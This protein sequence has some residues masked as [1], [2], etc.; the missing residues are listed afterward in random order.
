MTVAV[1]I[2][3]TTFCDLEHV[4]LEG[5]N[6]LYANAVGT[7]VSNVT[8]VNYD[9]H[10]Y[11]V[12]SAHH[13][14]GPHLYQESSYLECCYAT[15]YYRFDSQ[16]ARNAAD[17]PR[18]PLSHNAI[19]RYHPQLRCHHTPSRSRRC[20]T[21]EP[22]VRQPPPEPSAGPRIRETPQSPAHLRDPVCDLRIPLP[23][24]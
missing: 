18:P 22:A 23:A 15:T 19:G 14:I 16:S 6:S 1:V 3:L 10:I 12:V 8:V 9:D 21:P 2:Q 11:V 17:R 5:W 24:R 20:P 7:T 13:S 4:L